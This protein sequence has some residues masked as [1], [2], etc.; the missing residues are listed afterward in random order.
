MFFTRFTVLLWFLCFPFSEISGQTF[1]ERLNEIASANHLIGMSVGVVCNGSVTDLFHFGQSDLTRN[2]PV[3]DSTMY[4]IASISKS[5]TATALMKLYDK[6][7]FSLDDNVSQ[8]LGFELVNPYFPATPVTFRMLLSHTSGLNDGTGYGYFLT[9]TSAQNP[10]PL[11]SSLLMQGGS[12]YSADMFLNKQPG[13]YFQYANINFGVVGTLIESLSGIRFDIFVRDS[14]LLPLGIRGS[15]NVSDITNINNVAVLYRNS[16][17]QADNYQGVP[18]PPRNLTGYVV[19]TNGLIFSPAG[20]LRISASDL[21][22][23]M[24][25]HQNFGTHEQGSVLD[26]ATAAMMH[27]TE[28]NFSGTNGNNYYNLFRRWGLGFHLTT[29]YPGGDIVINGVEMIGHPGEAYGLISDM[30]FEHAKKFGLVFVTNGY[31]GTQGYLPGTNSAFYVPEE[32]IFEAIDQYHFQGCFPVHTHDVATGPAGMT[33]LQRTG[34][35]CFRKVKVGDWISIYD[36]MGRE[37]D[38]FQADLQACRSCPLDPGL[39][40]YVIRSEGVRYSGRF[41]V[42]AQ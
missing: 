27:E 36:I 14:V 23:F 30:Y 3:T 42:P 8:Y 31:S 1:H 29:N 41:L 12:F 9:A 20:G 22:R 28:W 37:F 11:L 18:P 39:Y 32:E 40:L 35:L 25:M 7:L 5:V 19:G 21:C 15:F 16:I 2:L 10:P 24:V 26:S 17:P 38:T 33:Y 4:R 34:E 13:S 6:G